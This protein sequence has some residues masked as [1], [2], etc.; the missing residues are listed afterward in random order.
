MKDQ[1]QSYAYA[2]VVNLGAAFLAA[3]DDE[4]LLDLDEAID[5]LNAARLLLRQEAK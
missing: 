3:T 1:W 5:K 4:A 2:A